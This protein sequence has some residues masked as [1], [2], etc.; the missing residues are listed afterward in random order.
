MWKKEIK[1][2]SEGPSILTELQWDVNVREKACR[3]MNGKYNISDHNVNIDK[4]LSNKRCT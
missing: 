4:K 3:K 1:Y 2:L